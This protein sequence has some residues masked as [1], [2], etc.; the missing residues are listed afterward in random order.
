MSL[1]GLV[2]CSTRFL[3]RASLRWVAAESWKRRFLPR[4][5]LPLFPFPRD[6]DEASFEV[7]GEQDGH[8]ITTVRRRSEGGAFLTGVFLFIFFFFFLGGRGRGARGG[9]G[10]FFIFS[11][12]VRFSLFFWGSSL[13]FPF[14]PCREATAKLEWWVVKADRS[15]LLF[16]AQFPPFFFPF[17]SPFHLSKTRAMEGG[18]GGG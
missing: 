8:V 10:S 17:S 14:F 5:N 16:R 13:F 1:E 9:G 12:F 18:G 15:V 3:L 11:F 7:F 6:V 2:P 4:L